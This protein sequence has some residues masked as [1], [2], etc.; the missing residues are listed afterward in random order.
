[1]PTIIAATGHDWDMEN[2]Q[3]T[4]APTCSQ[5]GVWTYSCSHD[6]EH[7]ATVGILIDPD[8]H[9]W[10]DA[11]EITETDIWRYIT[12][13]TV[14]IDGEEV[15]WDTENLAEIQDAYRIRICVHDRLHYE[16]V[17]TE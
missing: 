16:L 14:I 1:M 11:G 9:E 3:V 17:S 15:A 4:R 10:G 2:G 12:Q 7:T 5:P 6:A 13:D 8:A